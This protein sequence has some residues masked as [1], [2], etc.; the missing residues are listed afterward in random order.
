MAD[1]VLLTVA[2]LTEVLQPPVT[3]VQV[4]LMV[5]LGRVPVAGWRKTGKPGHPHPEYDHEEIA[6][7]HQALLP[8][9]LTGHGTGW[10]EGTP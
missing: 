7:L 6:R 4:T 2:E 5:K 10:K 1:R 9:L 8:W 3:Q